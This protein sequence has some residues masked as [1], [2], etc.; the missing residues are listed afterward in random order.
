MKEL[1]KDLARPFYF[2]TQS[3]RA[4]YDHDP[5]TGSLAPKVDAPRHVLLVV[6]DAL[7]P[8]AVPRVGET[9]LTHAIAPAPWTFPSVTSIHS[10]TYPHDHGA[11]AHTS[12]DDETY[13]MPAQVHGLDVLPEVFERAGYETFAGCAF[14]MPFLALRGWYRSHRVYPNAP[15]ETVVDRYL[16]WRAGRERT[17]AYIHLGDL[18]APLT[19]PARYR[20]RRDVDTSIP[21]IENI[22]RHGADFDPADPACRRYREHRLRL[23]RAANDY[24]GD[25]LERLWDSSEG[26]TLGVVVGDHGE[27]HFEHHEI[28]RQFTDSRPNYGVGHGGTPLDAVARVPVWVSEE[29]LLPVGGTASLVDLPRTLVARITDAHGFG[30]YDWQEGIPFDRI[31]LCEGSRYGAERKAAYRGNMK[32]IRSEHDD[33]TLTATI[34]G[35]GEDPEACE[36]FEIVPEADQEALL[37]AL[38]D[39]WENWGTRE[40]TGQMVREQLEAL[41]YR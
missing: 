31:A 28:D 36:C 25:E 10:G 6:I 2:L 12:P 33:L 13:A 7:R 41:G 14:P 27:A 23:Y 29:D 15:A 26:R 35:E 1:L 5:P 21:G 32:V 18:H 30:G 39:A 4:D 8:D 11:V 19:P 22:G 34:G 9:T 17:F 3:K 38:P 16:R 40:E 24:V 37:D 20:E